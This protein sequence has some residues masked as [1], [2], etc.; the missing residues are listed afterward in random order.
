MKPPPSCCWNYNFP[1]NDSNPV[2]K[3][4]KFFQVLPWLLFT[5]QKYFDLTRAAVSVKQ[6]QAGT[7]LVNLAILLCYFH[8][9]LWKTRWMLKLECPI[10][11][12]RFTSSIKY[13]KYF[14]NCFKLTETRNG[15]VCNACVLVVKRWR[16]LP[17]KSKNTKNWNHVVD[18]RNGPGIKNIPRFKSEHQHP[19]KFE[20]IKRKHRPK[21]LNISDSSITVPDFIDLSYW[22]R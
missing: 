2:F 20:K 17:D 15:D 3:L 21:K 1:C 14:T 22:T 9:T 16:N 12:S 11:S 19:E 6:S 7:Y 13:E 5:N 8:Y 18:A 10:F 4:R